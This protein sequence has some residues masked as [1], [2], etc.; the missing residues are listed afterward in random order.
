MH[1]LG[2]TFAL[3]VLSEAPISCEDYEREEAL[4]DR[5]RFL[6]LKC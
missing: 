6:K 4:R 5:S 1:A 2:R 3:Y